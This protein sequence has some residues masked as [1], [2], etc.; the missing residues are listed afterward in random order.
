[1]NQALDTSISSELTE[2]MRTWRHEIHQ[3]PETAYE[4]FK[5]AALVAKVL[6]SV[7]IEVHTGLAETGVVGVLKKGTSNRSIGLR[8]DM[9]ALDILEENDL[10]Y[11]SQVTGKMHACGH[12]GHTAMLLGAAVHLANNVEFDGTVVFIFQPAEEV[13][14]GALKMLQEGLFEKFPVD[15]VF[16][17]HNMPGIA[18]GQFAICEGPL[19]ASFAHFE[20]E[21][22]G[23]GGHSSAPHLNIDPVAIGADLIQQWQLIVPQKISSAE[24]A[25]IATTEFHA[26]TAFNI[27]PETAILRGSCRAL[28]NDVAKLIAEQMKQTAERVCAQHGATCRLDYHQAYPVLVNHKEGVELALS[29]AKAVVGDA[30]VIDN[31]EASM[32]S[33]DFAEFL[34]EC[35]GAY[36]FL[37]NGVESRGGCMIHNPGYDFNDENLPIGARYWS[38]LVEQYLD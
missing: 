9:D 32:G 8:A 29:A 10:D 3:H 28:S 21:I 17:L 25:V 23:K 18:T 15:M 24:R 22:F 38:M 36:I 7:G 35:P 6:E 27:C 26:G 20:C 13:R 19:M 11:C 16:G 5:T 34:L 1:M 31:Q 33:E 12:D 14:G 4:E 2:Q 37:G 30:N